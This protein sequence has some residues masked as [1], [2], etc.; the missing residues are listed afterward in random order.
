M[1][2]LNAGSSGR[3]WSWREALLRCPQ[4]FAYEK[5]LGLQRENREAL[6]KGSLVHIGLAHANVELLCEQNGWEN[7]H[8]PWR[9]AIAE[10]AL[11]EDHEIGHGEAWQQWVELA[12]GTVADYLAQ[13]E[14]PTVIA[15]EHRVEM[16]I[17][18]DGS[19]VDPP[20]DAEK[21]S[22]MATDPKLALMGPPYLHTSRIDL[23]ERDRYGRY[24]VTDYKTCYVIDAR[25]RDGFALSGQ[26]LGLTLWGAKT[27]GRDFGGSALQMLRLIKKRDRFPRVIPSP[28]PWALKEWGKSVV[29]SEE[30]LA[31]LLAKDPR[32]WPKTFSE[33]GP[34][35]DRYGPC[36]Y[37][38][39]CLTGKKPTIHP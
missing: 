5:L 26:I 20:V 6:I 24:W 32:H 27:Y 39:Y 21:R 1:K 38:D 34:C 8:M 11:Q 13:R 14:A 35:M 9:D 31:R 28:A 10:L 30:R 16:W 18:A 3:G 12:T 17:D 4:Q 22:A 15:V 7:D 2:L 33:Q 23:L 19:L 36:S 29:E 25:K 37:R